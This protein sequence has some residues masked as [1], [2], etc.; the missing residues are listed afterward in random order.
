MSDKKVT[1]MDGGMGRLLEKIGAPFRQP[2]WSALPLMEAPQYVE[3]AHQAFIDAGAEIIITNT[4]AVVPFHIGQEKFDTDGRRL[5]KL[6]AEIAKQ[7]IQNSGKDIKIAGS[8]P[9]AFGSYRPDL[10]DAEKAEAIYS[11]LIEEQ[12]PYIDFWLAETVSSTN[13]AKTIASFLKDSKKPLWVSFTLKDREDSGDIPQLRS[14]ESINTALQTALDIKAEAILFNCSQPEEI[15][16]ALLIL[17]EKEAPLFYGAYA[18]AFP[19]MKKDALANSTITELRADACPDNYLAF[20]RKW[21]AA[22]ASV[23]G[24]CCGIGPDHIKMLKKLNY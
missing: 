11:P 21:Q 15:E 12:E 6:A 1:I 5:I 19:A 17:A 20:A 4:Y 8:L 7:T 2:E 16:P 23:I 10:F 14:G 3:Q 9:P 22:G 24:G 18:N 13:E